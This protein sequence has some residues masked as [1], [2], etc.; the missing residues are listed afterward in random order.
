M[1]DYPYERYAKIRDLRELSDYKVTKLAGIKGTATISNWKNGKYTPKDDKMQKIADTLDVSLDYLKG[2]KTYMT[3][4]ICGFDDD[5]LDDITH[6][7]HIEFHERF[8]KIKDKY[9]FFKRYGVADKE[10]TDSIF[11][12]RNY[13][14]SLEEK[15]SA[16]EKYLESSFSLEIYRN[17][18]DIDNLN[19]DDFCK[20]EVSTFHEDDCI[21][22]EFIDSLIDK[23]GVDR[24]FMDGNGYLLAR[25][26]KNP[27]LMRLLTYAEKLKPETLNMLEVQAK[28]LSEQ[29]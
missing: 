2:S 14:K 7:K 17:D 4:P 26:S 29:K 19:Y 27:Q 16:F 11:E 9:P 22:K 3:C 28:A 15:M 8:L 24:D 6:K 1:G 21:S 25:A 12:F 20:T 18:Y 10:R 13:K 23:Y 5:L